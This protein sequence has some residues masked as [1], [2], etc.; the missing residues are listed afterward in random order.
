MN[1][2][3]SKNLQKCKKS[4]HELQ[5]FDK[6]TNNPLDIH[7]DKC[8]LIYLL[9]LS[10]DMDLKYARI[11]QRQFGN[12]LDRIQEQSNDIVSEKKLLADHLSSSAAT[13][14][15]SMV[16]S[17]Q[18]CSCSIKSNSNKEQQSTFDNLDV[19]SFG[20]RCSFDEITQTQQLATLEIKNDIPKDKETMIIKLDLHISLLQQQIQDSEATLRQVRIDIVVQL[21]N[22]ISFCR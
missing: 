19:N 12:S 7:A 1:K 15:S 9:Q 3:A 17:K 13:N 16:S 20:K 5:T 14:T 18:E 21:P 8:N 11:T 2:F 22:L 6:E 10:E 4:K